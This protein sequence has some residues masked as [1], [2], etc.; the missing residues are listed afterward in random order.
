MIQKKIIKINKR[1]SYKNLQIES[2]RIGKNPSPSF[3]PPSPSAFLFQ[4]MKK[5]KRKEKKTF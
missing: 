5:K 1:K 4:W 3:P 2:Q